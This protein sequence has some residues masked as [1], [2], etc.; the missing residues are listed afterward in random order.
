MLLKWKL[1][2]YNL[3]AMVSLLALQEGGE[4]VDLSK[5]TK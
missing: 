2:L 4:I 3:I 5:F 1:C